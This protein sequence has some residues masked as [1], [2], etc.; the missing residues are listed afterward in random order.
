MYTQQFKKQTHFISEDRVSK[1]HALEQAVKIA[2]NYSSNYI[3][4]G[5]QG[6]K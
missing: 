4:C 2:E 3:V 1:I 5:N 6:L